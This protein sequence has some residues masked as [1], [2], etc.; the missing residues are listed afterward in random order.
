MSKESKSWGP[1]GRPPE[2][3]MNGTNKKMDL[4]KYYVEQMSKAAATRSP[5]ARALKM[6]EIRALYN[7]DFP[8]DDKA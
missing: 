2:S 3:V 8:P 7:R 5:K 1:L 4:Y 6:A